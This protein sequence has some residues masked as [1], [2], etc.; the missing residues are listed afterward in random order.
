M[1]LV[2]LVSRKR[3][4]DGSSAIMAAFPCRCDSRRLL[5]VAAIA[6]HDF[7]P[8]VGGTRHSSRLRAPAD[9]RA[10]GARGSTPDRAETDQ[11]EA[12]AKP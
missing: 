6:A 5:R 3:K 8:P 2:W 9:F 11:V 10:R 1:S 7:V 12:R 4:I